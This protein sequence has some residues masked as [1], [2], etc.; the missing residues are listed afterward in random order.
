MPKYVASRT[1]TE[2]LPW[3]GTLL[4]GDAATAVA[5]R[6]V[7]R[8]AMGQGRPTVLENVRMRLQVVG[9]ETF[10]SGVTLLRFAP[11]P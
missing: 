9:S 4:E 3:N 11:A 6:R 8:N 10:D 5:R 1:L 2:P 7:T